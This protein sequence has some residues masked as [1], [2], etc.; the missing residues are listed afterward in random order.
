MPKTQ[1][2]KRTHECLGQRFIIRS[3]YYVPR[4]GVGLG[5]F[6]VLVIL[7]ITSQAAVPRATEPAAQE[8]KLPYVDFKACGSGDFG[9]R[10]PQKLRW[11]DRL[12]SSWQRKRV[13][14]G[15]IK[16]G[17]EVTMIA[18]VNVIYE[19]DKAVILRQPDSAPPLK[20]GE[21]VLGYGYDADGTRS[22]WN[23]GVW[24]REDDEQVIEGN[25]PCGFADKTVCTIKIIHKGVQQWWVQ[26]KTKAGSTGWVLAGKFDGDKA[27]YDPNF[28]QGCRD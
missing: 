5:T 6:L 9:P 11:S 4:M 10:L 19:P 26:V 13:F 17:E 12:Y 22:F 21:T 27:V 18:G 25:F 8:P 16:R 14:L 3:L 20:P 23:N 2:V 24:F 1:L 28:E 7:A 15:V